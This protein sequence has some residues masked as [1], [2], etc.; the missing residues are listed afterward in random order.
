MRERSDIL[1][2]LIN[3]VL[4]YTIQDEMCFYSRTHS[5]TKRYW[6]HSLL[7]S[8]LSRP[9]SRF[10][11]ATL[12]RQVCARPALLLFQA[13]AGTQNLIEGA[14]K[15]CIHLAPRERKTCVC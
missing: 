6:V 13:I 4:P 7:L 15:D 12:C 9:A 11:Q 1:E 5:D 10:S 2:V 3:T 14:I 8:M